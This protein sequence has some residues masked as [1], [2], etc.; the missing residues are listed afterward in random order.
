ME[1]PSRHVSVAAIFER[2][3]ASLVQARKLLDRLLTMREVEPEAEIRS[4]LSS[5]MLTPVE[6]MSDAQR[7][8]FEVLRR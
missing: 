5:A 2:Y 7:E 6:A 3:G 1:D 4:A 8:W